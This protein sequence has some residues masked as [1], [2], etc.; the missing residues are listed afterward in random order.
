MKRNLMTFDYD[1]DLAVNAVDEIMCSLEYYDDAMESLGNLIINEGLTFGDL[2]EDYPAE[3]K[4][5]NNIYE[6]VMERLECN[7]VIPEN[8]IDEV[9]VN[10]CDE[11]FD[12]IDERIEWYISNE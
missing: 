11:L 9:D 8:F 6:E 1:E 4:C 10:D 2:E 3:F 7:E 5:Y 12:Y